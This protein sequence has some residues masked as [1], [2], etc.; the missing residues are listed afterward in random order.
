VAKYTVGSVPYLNAKPLVKPL[1]WSGDAS[2]VSVEFD[3]PSKLPEML[4]QGRAQ[5]ILVSSISA[6]TDP[7]ATVADGLSIS[8]QGEVL[9]VRLFSKVPFPQI[10]TLAEDQS[11]MTSNALA[12]ILLAEFYH[13]FPDSRPMAPSGE[14]MLSECDACLM[15]GDNGMRFDA[16]DLHVMDLGKAWHELTGLPFVWAVWKGNH[17]L[18]EELVGLLQ[19]SLAT[20]LEN[21]ERVVEES[22]I[23]TGF[24][25]E[26]CRHYL[27]DIMDYRLTDAH[28]KGLHEYGRLLTK[29]SLTCKVFPLRLVK[30]K[31]AAN[32]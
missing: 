32:A 26:E 10:R 6:I 22:A 27:A 28:V 11:S 17:T 18:T 16:G 12:K 14:E 4:E 21:K 29:H 13:V 25:R 3:M 2:L 20:S 24:S 19:G 31:A 1:L 7:E 30:A 15:I 9:S 5:A 23:E 8:T